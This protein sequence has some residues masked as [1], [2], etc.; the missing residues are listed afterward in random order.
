[1]DVRVTLAEALEKTCTLDKGELMESLEI[2]PD[3]GMGDYALPCFKLSKALRKSPQDIAK[4]L[5]ETIEKPDIIESIQV[6]GGYLNFFLDRSKFAFETMK[7]ILGADSGYGRQDIGKGRNICIDYSSI[8]IAKPFHIGHLSTTVIGNSLYR[9]YEFLGFNCIG[10]NHL[11]D[12]GTQFGK[13]IVAFKKWS[14]KE[15]IEKDSI[16]VMLQLY[17]KFHDEA[18]KDESLDAQARVWFK[19]IEDGDEEALELFKFFKELTLRE[20]RKVYK[21]LGIEFDSYD[22]ESF[23]NDKMQPVIDELRQKNL[24][25][26]SDGA[27]VVD[28]EAYK[29]PPCLILK[30]D[31]A[32]LYATRDI[33]AAKYRKETY[34]F[35]K[36]LYVVAYQQNLHFA[37]CFKVIELMGYPWAKDLEHVAFGMV[38][39]EEGTL[40]TRKG[41]VV[42]LEDVLNKAIEKTTEIIKEKSPDLDDKEGVAKMV[43]V[44]AVVFSTLLNNRIKDIVFSYDRILNFE[45]E[46]GPYV[47]YTHSRCCSLLKKAGIEDFDSDGCEVL[48]NDEEFALL[49]LMAAFPDCVEDACM[50]NEPSLITRMAVNIAQAYN[51]FYFEHRILD[52][53]ENICKAR[54]ALSFAVRNI[55]KDALYLIGL[56]APERM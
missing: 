21:L 46:T 15:A 8:N 30:A 4:M 7:S 33:T 2:P 41:K 24:L 45:G 49:K 37:Q 28:L 42:F 56:E 14:N 22:G 44:G 6:Q 52:E 19:K 53:A 39:M 11:G 40:S 51:K 10:I 36:A 5:M 16:N 48:N 43:G 9:I 26:E 31:G 38:S 32:T 29:M 34:D 3:T 20:V 12:W 13:L 17:I 47:Q 35:H 54:L 27:Y 50:K 1:M 18:E 55:I 23:Y 25:T